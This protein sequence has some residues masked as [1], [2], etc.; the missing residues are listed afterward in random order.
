MGGRITVESRPREGSLFS[1]TVPLALAPAVPEDL[2]DGPLPSD[3]CKRQSES[4]PSA[5]LRVLLVDDSAHNRL[6]IRGYLKDRPY[7]ID[8]A[9]DGVTALES[10]TASCYHLVLMDIQM[11]HMDGYQAIRAMRAWEQEQARLPTPI[12]VLTA[13]AL[14]HEVEQSMEAGA[15]Q[16][17]AKPIQKEVL[18][19]TI[20]RL[21]SR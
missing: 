17:L 7:I 4:L 13:H 16:H 18:L 11:P 2:R 8:E 3:P 21:L 14:T 10:F 19:E 12:L 6:L 15:D 5:P 9:E 1:F 20:D